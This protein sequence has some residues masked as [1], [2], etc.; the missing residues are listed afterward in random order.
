MNNSRISKNE[1]DNKINEEENEEDK[2]K[3]YNSEDENIQE[4]KIKISSESEYYKGIKF[5][6][7][8]KILYVGTLFVTK[9]EIKEEFQGIVVYYDENNELKKF[10]NGI[11]YYNNEGKKEEF[12]GYSINY[13]N[14]KI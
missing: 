3:Y 7:D 5:I 8:K 10:Y 4:F 2:Y 11:I 9:E 6:K 12:R 1:I 13:E 14:N